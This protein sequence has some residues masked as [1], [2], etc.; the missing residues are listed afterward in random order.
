MTQSIIFVTTNPGKIGAFTAIAAHFGI[1]VVQVK[2]DL[3]E[4]QAGSVVEVAVNKAEQAVKLI[5]KPVVVEDTGF[6]I[7]ALNG[8]PG[9]YIKYAL[10]TIGPEGLVRLAAPFP[11]ATCHF[12]NAMCYA[13]PDGTT[14][15]F[16][17]NSATGTLAKTIDPSPAPNAWS[18]LWRIFI[19]TGSDKTLSALA[20]D[21]RNALMQNWQAGSVY[22]QFVR[23][24][25]NQSNSNLA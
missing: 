24:L 12:V 22:G 13:A 2:A 25:A 3:I 18:Q 10:E 20:E 8:F 19:P 14:H 23:W 11:N 6:A 15:T 17:D 4:P 1:E 7:D 5:G 21:E 16:V 9:A